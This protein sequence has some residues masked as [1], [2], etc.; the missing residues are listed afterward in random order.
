MA[1]AVV[2]MLSHPEERKEMGER[3]RKRV[4]EAFELGARCR[5]MEDELLALLRPGTW[6]G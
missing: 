5:E 1:R 6:G 3:G 2:W 4:K